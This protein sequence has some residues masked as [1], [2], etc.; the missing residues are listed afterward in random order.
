VSHPGVEVSPRT[1]AARRCTNQDCEYG[2]RWIVGKMRVLL[3]GKL[4]CLG[5][6]CHTVHEPREVIDPESEDYR[7]WIGSG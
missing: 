6:G 5:K 7:L 4:S 1:K 2:G 3:N